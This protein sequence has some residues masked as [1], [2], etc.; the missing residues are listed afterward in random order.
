MRIMLDSIGDAR[1]ASPESMLEALTKDERIRRAVEQ[2][3]DEHSKLPAGVRIYTIR[4]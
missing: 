4:T 2:D 1:G 3:E